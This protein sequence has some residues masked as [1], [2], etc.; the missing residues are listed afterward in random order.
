MPSWN[1]SI[2]RNWLI[3]TYLEITP[4]IHVYITTTGKGHVQKYNCPNSVCSEYAT[5]CW[6]MLK[7]NQLLLGNQAAAVSYI[8]WT[9]LNL[10][11]ICVRSY[12]EETAA[13]ARVRHGQLC[14]RWSVTGYLSHPKQNAFLNWIGNQGI[15]QSMKSPHTDGPP[16]YSTYNIRIAVIHLEGYN[17]CFLKQTCEWLASYST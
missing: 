17:K 10:Y 7:P 15:E 2:L 9:K 14:S 16:T 11:T 5:I 8:H 1:N 6:Y 13:M 4:C 12:V 3:L